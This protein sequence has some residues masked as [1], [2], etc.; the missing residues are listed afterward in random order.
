[1]KNLYQKNQVTFSII[2]IAIYVVLMSLGDYLSSL[3]GIEKMFTMPISIILAS[4]LLLWISKEKLQGEFGLVK[5]SFPKKTYLYFIPL[6]ITVSVNFWGGISVN[7]TILETVLFVI[8]MLLVGVLEEI[9]FRG[10]LF[11]ALSKDNKAI[12][13]IVSSVTFGFGHIINLLG[14]ADFISTLLQIA[15]ATM[16]GFTFTIIFYKSGSLIPCIITHSVMNATSVIA[17]KTS[18][19]LEVVTAIVLIIVFASYA[20][21]ILKTEKKSLKTMEN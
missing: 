15:Y 12:A 20:L 11:K 13:I 14:G 9:I 1:M 10:F 19:N 21:W 6:V 16:A 4:I 18:P 17:S 5:G 2:W 7:Y 3:V 8:S